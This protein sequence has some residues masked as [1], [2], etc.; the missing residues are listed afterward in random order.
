[1]EEALDFYLEKHDPIIRAERILNAKNT[2]TVE[3]VKTESA[4]VI[5]APRIWTASIKDRKNSQPQRIQKLSSKRV[6][7]NHIKHLAFQRDKGQCT[8]TQPDGTRCGQTRWTEIHHNY[9]ENLA[10]V[11]TLVI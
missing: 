3:T 5:E 9:R 10:E 11:I 2:Q 7:P 4:Q 1:M 6:I 8:Q